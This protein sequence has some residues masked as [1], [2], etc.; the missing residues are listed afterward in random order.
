MQYFNTKSSVAPGAWLN[1]QG[2]SGF[3]ASLKIGLEAGTEAL[4]SCWAALRACTRAAESLWHL[5]QGMGRRQ[6]R[7][8]AMGSS[9]VT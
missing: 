9:R 6:S 2:Q 3:L 1:E 5:W 7:E 4:P 8:L